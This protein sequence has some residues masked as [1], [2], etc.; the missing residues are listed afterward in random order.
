MGW[1][2]LPKSDSDL[3]KARN[4]ETLFCT[5]GYIKKIPQSK[6]DGSNDSFTILMVKT[7]CFV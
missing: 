1:E 6:K 5:S 2:L 4:A 3:L 7:S